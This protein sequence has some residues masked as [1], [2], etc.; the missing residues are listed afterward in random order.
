MFVYMCVC[1]SQRLPNIGCH[2]TGCFLSY[3]YE[4]GSLIS[5][6]LTNNLDRLASESQNSLYLPRMGITSV[7]HHVCS[8]WGF[9]VEDNH[10]LT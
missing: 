9:Q 1:V 3:L 10:D 8:P 6:G 2:I 5:L 7:Y 4:T